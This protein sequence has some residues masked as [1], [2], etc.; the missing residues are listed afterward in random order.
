MVDCRS[1]WQGH[2]ATFE[3]LWTLYTLQV[4][5][6]NANYMFKV[7]HCYAETIGW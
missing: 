4:K 3:S 6:I 7:C 5:S 1:Q 2:L